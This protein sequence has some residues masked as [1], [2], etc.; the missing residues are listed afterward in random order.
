[1]IL[2]ENQVNKMSPEDTMI[3]IKREHHLLKL[4]NQIK[5]AQVTTHIQQHLVNPD[6]QQ[7]PQITTNHIITLQAI[8]TEVRVIIQ[9]QMD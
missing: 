6:Q 7:H 2:R 4:D 3:T 1:L 9:S 8:T 5:A